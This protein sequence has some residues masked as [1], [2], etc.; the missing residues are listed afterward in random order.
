[1]QLPEF[2]EAGN[3]GVAVTLV[4][5]SRLARIAGVG[6][7]PHSKTHKSPIIAAKQVTLGAVG[8]CCQKVSEAE[9]MVEGGL[10]DILISYNLLGAQKMGR[11]GRLLQ[12]AT[13]TVAPGRVPLSISRLKASDMRCSLR[14][15]SP[16]DS[17]L[18]W[19]REGVCGAVAGLAAVCAVMVSPVVFLSMVVSRV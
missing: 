19:G 15:D 17:G 3:I 1:M 10:D 5:S 8:V 14:D 16:S 6:L 7:R 12:R 2:V 11:L 13:I 4:I 9:V 18:A